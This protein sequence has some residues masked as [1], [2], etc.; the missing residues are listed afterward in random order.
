LPSLCA[1]EEKCVEDRGVHLHATMRLG[2]LP[3]PERQAV[4]ARLCASYVSHHRNRTRRHAVNLSTREP[5]HREADVRMQL[6]TS[7]SLSAQRGYQVN[8][9]ASWQ[10]MVAA[11]T[12]ADVDVS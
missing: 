12:D 2:L 8:Q 11:T 1:H 10:A 4:V 6:C 3:N 5:Y 9:R 7:T